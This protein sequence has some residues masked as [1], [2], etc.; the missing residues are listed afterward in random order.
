MPPLRDPSKLDD[1]VKRVQPYAF[2]TDWTILSKPLIDRCHAL[3]VKVFSD[4]LG[5]HE[6]IADYQKAI[7]EGID[8]IQTD[9]PLR[10]LRDRVEQVD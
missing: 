3:G 9:H 7:A 4:A 6:T 2:D 10:V 1:V 8:L 5:S